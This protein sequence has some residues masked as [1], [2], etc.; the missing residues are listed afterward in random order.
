MADPIELYKT[1][2]VTLLF[3]EKKIYFDYEL[4]TY[5]TGERDGIKW[6]K[7]RWF[8]KNLNVPVRKGF[9]KS[10]FLKTPEYPTNLY[11]YYQLGVGARIQIFGNGI[12]AAP[13]V[14]PS[15]Y[16]NCLV[17]IDFDVWYHAF[18]PVGTEKMARKA[19]YSPENKPLIALFRT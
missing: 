11:L 7:G 15:V 4:I 19:M 5:E 18:P 9:K 10:P 3:H 16:S 6:G 14:V 12:W 1:Q 8:E 13:N 2:Y 17:D